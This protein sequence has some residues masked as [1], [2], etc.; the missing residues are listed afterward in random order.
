MIA[1]HLPTPNL[2]ACCL[3]KK[4]SIRDPLEPEGPNVKPTS[5]ISHLCD[6]GLCA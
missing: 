3:K 5:A 6:L 1:S 4:K 2:E